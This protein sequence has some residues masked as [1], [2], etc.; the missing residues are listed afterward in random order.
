MNRPSKRV[1]IA[2]SSQVVEM[3][4]IEPLCKTLY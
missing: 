4:G 2:S 1:H 3:R